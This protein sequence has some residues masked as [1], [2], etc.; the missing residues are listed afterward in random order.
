[1]P[2]AIRPSAA[3]AE[4]RYALRESSGPLGGVVQLEVLAPALG[5][6]CL[7]A[8]TAWLG[9]R[10]GG[11][12]RPPRARP[13]DRDAAPPTRRAA[14]PTAE[15]PSP[16]DAAAEAM[17]RVVRDEL[18][19]GR[20]Q[21]AIA[22]WLAL[23]AAGLDAHA[24]PTL[25][26]RL[27]ALLRDSGRREQAVSALRTALARAG[28]ESGLAIA[29]RVARAAVDLDARLALEA[30]WHA[31]A[32]PDLDL[33]DRQDLEKLVARVK[34]GE[35]RGAAE[36]A[37]AP[38]PEPMPTPAAPA[39]AAGEPAPER[40]APAGRPE[41]IDLG[42]IFRHL[43]VELGV[44]LAIEPSGLRVW[45]DG[46]VERAVGWRE[47]DAIAVGAVEGLGSKPVLVVDL[48]SGWR[49]PP[50][51]PLRIVRLRGDRFDPR[52]LVEGHD[53]PVDALRELV[54]RLLGETGADP[55]P[56]L[57]AARGRPFAGFRDLASFECDVL[58]AEDEV[59]SD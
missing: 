50:S 39:E 1:V 6:A 41:P 2:L 8:V 31:L 58:G 45:L 43:E 21:A 10:N 11:A 16:G 4:F 49:R 47:V 20:S 52:K 5:M 53:A 33:L 25:A 32:S 18:Q 13:R 27:A 40:R 36:A 55:L 44:P 26:I 22:N 23:G 38:A 7:V 12:A 46:G 14:S 17:L 34:R 9:L 24:D 48:V 59:D 3:A 42:A 19:H 30:A 15:A 51:E 37:A 28:G 56:D 57:R 29:T 54:D 35:G